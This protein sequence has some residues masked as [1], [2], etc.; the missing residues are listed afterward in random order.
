[1]RR[2]YDEPALLQAVERRLGHP[3][4][5]MPADLSLPESIQAKMVRGGGGG[6]W[7]RSPF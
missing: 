2:R 1:M 7:R 3:V 6:P 4:A 5:R